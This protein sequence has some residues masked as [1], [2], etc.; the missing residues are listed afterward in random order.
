MVR[1]RTGLVAA[2]SY[3]ISMINTHYYRGWTG[4]VDS[5]NNLAEITTVWTL[6][7][8][9]HKIQVKELRIF[10]DSLL[11][12][13]WLQGNSMIHATNLTHR[14]SRIR[15]LI[16]LFDQV[17]FKHIYRRHNLEADILS[18]KGI[19]SPEGYLHIEEVLDGTNIR[20]FTHRIF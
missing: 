2:A 11:V 10:G 4:L 5:T 19:G 9:A 6:L 15:E 1:P 14:C 3:F 16:K 17:H 18:K 20:S 13:G 8:W 12:I 7:Y